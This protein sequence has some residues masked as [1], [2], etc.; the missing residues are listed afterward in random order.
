M[1]PHIQNWAFS[2][3]LAFRQLTTSIVCA[4]FR[5]THVIFEPP[6]TNLRKYFDLQQISLLVSPYKFIS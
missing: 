2:D 5:R 1:K 3:A 4:D 6:S